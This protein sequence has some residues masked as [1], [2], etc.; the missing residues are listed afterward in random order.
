MLAKRGAP[1]L[2]L[3]L[4]HA[5]KALHCLVLVKRGTQPPRLLLHAAKAVR[6]TIGKTAQPRA[7]LHSKE[8]FGCKLALKRAGVGGGDGATAPLKSGPRDP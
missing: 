1:A 6:R 8:P 3:L 5:A 7:K 2:V 4:L